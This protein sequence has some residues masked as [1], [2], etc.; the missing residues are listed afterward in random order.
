MPE[1]RGGA[2]PESIAKLS[3]EK[4]LVDK[5]LVC[6]TYV[7]LGKEPMQDGLVYVHTQAMS[8]EHQATIDCERWLFTVKPQKVGLVDLF[9][10]AR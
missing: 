10:R 1:K 8:S 4:V 6:Q 5:M 7:Q 2:F 9:T 3:K